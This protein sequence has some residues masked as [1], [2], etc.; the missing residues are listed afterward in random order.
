MSKQH[1]QKAKPRWRLS[2]DLSPDMLV[3][4]DGTT[5]YLATAVAQH[6]DFAY[7]AEI[8]LQNWSEDIAAFFA[9]VRSAYFQAEMSGLPEFP[10]MSQTGADGTSQ[11]AKPAQPAEQPA[12]ESEA[13]DDIADQEEDPA[14]EILPEPTDDYDIDVYPATADEPVEPTLAQPSQDHPGLF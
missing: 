6:G 5:C 4:S 2:F 11:A 7:M 12:K 1:S 13:P 3:K 10:D 9:L 8:R 14:P